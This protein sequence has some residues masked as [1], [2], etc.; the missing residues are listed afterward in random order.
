MR[1]VMPCY[2]LEFHSLVPSVITDA[3]TDSKV[4]KIHKRGVELLEFAFLD[5]SNPTSRK[6]G[7]SIHSRSHMSQPVLLGQQSR[8]PTLVQREEARRAFEAARPAAGSTT[9]AASDF[10]PANLLNKFKRFSFMGKPSSPASQT[11]IA[12]SPAESPNKRNS[13]LSVASVSTQADAS[14]SSP[15]APSLIDIPVIPLFRDISPGDP[16]ATAK[17]RSVIE[18]GGLTPPKKHAPGYVWIIRQYLRKDLKDGPTAEI[19]F[20]WRKKRRRPTRSSDSAMKAERRKSVQADTGATPLASF[21]HQ[22]GSQAM[23]L[24]QSTPA[25]APSMHVQKPSDDAEIIRTSLSYDRPKEATNPLDRRRSLSSN[26]LAANTPRASMDGERPTRVAELLNPNKIFKT[27]TGGS[28]R[29]VTVAD[30]GSNKPKSTKSPQA[31]VSDF[32][33]ADEDSGEESDPEDSERPW[34]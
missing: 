19:S 34:M 7:R 14:S 2:N 25:G 32:G 28:A 6:T 4:A 24:R 17:S 16:R 23:Y 5:V 13:V 1:K 29:S 30:N 11:G 22:A 27:R 10:K 9:L 15:P 31:S 20:E 3:G 8:V 12:P 18:N 33:H 21:T 26:P